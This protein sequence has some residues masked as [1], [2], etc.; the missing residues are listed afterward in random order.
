MQETKMRFFQHVTL[1]KP[2]E[3]SC[4]VKI[5]CHTEVRILSRKFSRKINL[6]FFCISKEM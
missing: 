2:F 6:K 5:M 4:C 3:I 1:G